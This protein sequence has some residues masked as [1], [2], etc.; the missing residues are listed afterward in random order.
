MI[1]C[2][3]LAFD[4]IIPILHDKVCGHFSIMTYQFLCIHGGEM[5]MTAMA[6]DLLLNAQIMTY[7]IGMITQRR[8]N[9]G[10]EGAEKKWPD[11]I[12]RESWDREG[13]RDREPRS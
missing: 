10:G 12:G 9:A 11:D 6:E 5:G 4:V 7:R 1:S 13:S 3:S 8:I 2:L